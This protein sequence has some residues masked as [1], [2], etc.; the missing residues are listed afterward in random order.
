MM[1]QNSFVPD[2]NGNLIGEK[3]ALLANLLNAN[4]PISR[5]HF[6]SRIGKIMALG[7]LS[8]FTLLAGTAHAAGKDKG[9]LPGLE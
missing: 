1:E 3:G 6:V 8:H 7:A 4:N 2:K 5:R 9:A